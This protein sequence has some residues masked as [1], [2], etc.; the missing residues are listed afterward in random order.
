MASFED[1][2]LHFAPVEVAERLLALCEEGG[3]RSSLFL[4]SDFDL[5]VYLDVLGFDAYNMTDSADQSREI[6][7]SRPSVN[8]VPS[9]DKAHCHETGH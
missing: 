5:A 4:S 2:E 1:P 8:L 7:F 3:Y 9:G 6:D